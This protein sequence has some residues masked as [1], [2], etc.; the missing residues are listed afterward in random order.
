MR[1]PRRVD[2]TAKSSLMIALIM[3]VIAFLVFFVWAAKTGRLDPEAGLTL[4]VMGLT[5]KV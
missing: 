4:L 2:P 1:A 3:H 5:E